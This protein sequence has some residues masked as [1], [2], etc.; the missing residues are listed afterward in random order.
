[1]KSVFLDTQDRV[2]ETQAFF[3][4][5]DGFFGKLKIHI[6]SPDFFATKGLTMKAT[7]DRSFDK[8]KTWT[9]PQG[10]IAVS[11]YNDIYPNGET[12]SSI[13]NSDGRGSIYR[14]TILADKSFKFGASIEEL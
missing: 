2:G 12:P 3:T 6:E 13:F 8:G 10:F 5:K 4:V 7:L 9:E 1:M 14:L 11:G